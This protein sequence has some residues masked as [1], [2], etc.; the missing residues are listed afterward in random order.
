MAENKTGN[1]F[2]FVAYPLLTL[3]KGNATNL[4]DDLL[5]GRLLKASN[6]NKDRC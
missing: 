2:T 6:L 5:G 4:S 3:G 1:A